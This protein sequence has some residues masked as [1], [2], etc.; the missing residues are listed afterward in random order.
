MTTDLRPAAAIKTLG[1]KLNQFESE[2]IREQFCRLGCRI[3]PF[4]GPADI[5]V[6]NS[7]TVTARTDSEA[8]NYSDKTLPARRIGQRGQAGIP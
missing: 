3:V 7:C 4:E 8:A 6:I 2:Q 5:Y 1:C